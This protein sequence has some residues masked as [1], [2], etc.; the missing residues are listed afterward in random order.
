MKRFK[1]NIQQF[2]EPGEPKTFTQEEVD[3]MIETRLKRENEKFEKNMLGYVAF[4]GTIESIDIFEIAIKKE[5]QGQ[6]FGEKLLTESMKNLIRDNENVEIKNIHFSGEKFLLEVNENN[7][8]ALKLY[9]KIGFE[10]IYVRKNYYGNN[11]NA[12]I[13]MKSI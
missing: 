6:C 9:K 12:I 13:M 3:K 4:Y 1:L 5:Y 2:A 11:E 8:K 7:E 10:E